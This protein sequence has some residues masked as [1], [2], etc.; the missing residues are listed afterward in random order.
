MT[1]TH[2]DTETHPVRPL[3]KSERCKRQRYS[4]VHAR[5]IGLTDDEPKSTEY[6][7]NKS[8]IILQLSGNSSD[9][10]GL[11]KETFVVNAFICFL[12]HSLRSILAF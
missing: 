2:L 7:S 9:I 5:H 8:T 11:I 12:V 10:D 3:V 4:F 1:E 6:E